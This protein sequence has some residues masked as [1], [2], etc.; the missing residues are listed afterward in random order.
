MKTL[1]DVGMDLDSDEEDS[2][3][4]AESLVSSMFDTRAE[5]DKVVLYDI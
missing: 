4:T 2:N 1:E 5:R 3:I